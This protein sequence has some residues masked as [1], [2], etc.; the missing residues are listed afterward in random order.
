[1]VEKADE[2]GDGCGFDCA[3]Y[4]STVLKTLGFKHALTPG[5]LEKQLKKSEKV[6]SVKTY[7]RE[8]K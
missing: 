5:G 4:I 2:L 1:M 6:T 7:R 8:K 3:N